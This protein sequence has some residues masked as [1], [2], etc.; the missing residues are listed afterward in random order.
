MLTTN[1]CLCCSCL[2][3]PRITDGGFYLLIML[4]IVEL[5]C[6]YTS[7]VIWGGSIPVCLKLQC[8][9]LSLSP[10]KDCNTGL[11]PHQLQVHHPLEKSKGQFYHKESLQETRGTAWYWLHPGLYSQSFQRWL[12]AGQE[13][14]P[15]RP[16]SSLPVL[17]R[18]WKKDGEWLFTW[19]DNDRTRGNDFKLKE[20]RFRLDV[21]KKFFTHK[22]VRDW[23]F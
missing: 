7:N 18:A 16:H 13:E 22:V 2:C 1:C 10:F 19:V 4:L 11:W 6:I 20:E 23:N 8:N 3:F 5:W 15:E 17:E 21:R 14:A 9:I 12:G